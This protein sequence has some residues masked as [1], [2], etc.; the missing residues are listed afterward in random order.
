MVRRRRRR[1]RRRSLFVPAQNRE[2]CPEKMLGTLSR[3]S[4]VH[5]ELYYLIKFAIKVGQHQIFRNLII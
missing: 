5:Y 4:T 1:R 3:T 2:K